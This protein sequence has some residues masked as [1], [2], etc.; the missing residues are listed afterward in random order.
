MRLVMCTVIWS[1]SNVGVDCIPFVETA[2]LCFG[3]SIKLMVC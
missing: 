3:M 2:E 1:H